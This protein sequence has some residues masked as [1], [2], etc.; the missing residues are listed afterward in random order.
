M[1]GM[2]FMRLQKPIETKVKAATTAS[3]IVIFLVLLILHFVPWLNGDGELV[4]DAITAALGAL[5][6]FLA[7]YMANHTPR[8]PQVPVTPVVPTVTP[9]P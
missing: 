3:P 8:P 1:L 4:A 5:G 7:G 6:T 2:A 9:T